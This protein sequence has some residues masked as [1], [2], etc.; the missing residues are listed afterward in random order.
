MDKKA[1]LG[2]LTIIVL[3]HVILGTI[4]TAIYY[5]H[6]QARSCNSDS[7]CGEN[8]FCDESKRCQFQEIV[9]RDAKE[10]VTVQKHNFKW[11]I[12]FIGIS[13][14]VSTFILYMRKRLYQKNQ[15][16]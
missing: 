13:I 2:T 7:E 14:I 8:S 15:I 6:V 12:I 9:T 16:L 10:T 1:Q 4:I 3:I 11:G 5:N